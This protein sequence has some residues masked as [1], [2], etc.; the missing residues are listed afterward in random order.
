MIA[1]VAGG[2]VVLPLLSLTGLAEL[3]NMLTVSPWLG[4]IKGVIFT[5][6]VAF[7]A[8]VFSKKGLFWRT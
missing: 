4:F 2:V 8:S 6:L 3:L 5:S 1:Y 7:T